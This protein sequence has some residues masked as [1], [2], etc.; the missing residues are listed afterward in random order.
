MCLFVSICIPLHTHTH[1]AQARFPS[2]VHVDLNV[3][4]FLHLSLSLSLSVCSR[5]FIDTTRVSI[6]ERN[7]DRQRENEEEIEYIIEEAAKVFFF[8]SLSKSMYRWIY[9]PC[10]HRKMNE[11]QRSSAISSTRKTNGSEMIYP[12]KIMSEYIS[13]ASNISSA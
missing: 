3:M 1:N 13:S 12:G 8:F 10:Y 7:K 4:F 6:G 2:G 11:I 9:L 5:C